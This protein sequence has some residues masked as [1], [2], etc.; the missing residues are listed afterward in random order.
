MLNV[1][2]LSA[3]YGAILAVND[4]SLEIPAGKMVALLGS[5]G[6]G[7]STT[8]R[9]IAGLHRAGAGTVTLDTT[10]ISRR[11][12]H[13]VVRAGLA[14]VPEGRM[15]VAPLTVEQNLKLSAYARRGEQNELLNRV[16]DLFP[17]LKERRHQT[18]GLM[19]GGEQQ[20][21]AFGRALMT[22]PKMLLL[23]EPSMGLAP[24][25]VDTVYEA[26]VAIHASGQSI[27]LVE[28]NAALAL[29][30]CDYAYVLQ[31]GRVVAEG[32][33]AELHDSAAL[34]AAYLG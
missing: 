5:N 2:M 30:I 15:V 6:A 20:M 24:V 19:S 23:D 25:I 18:S 12:A 8:L 28:Q 32:T 29:P 9:T 27:L 11:P 31:R 26:I 16:Y 22:D 13:R 7:K 4:V 21:L 10:E 33:G 1:S 14:L 34:H 17:R 3:S